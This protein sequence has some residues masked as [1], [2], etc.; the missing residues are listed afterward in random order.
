MW[1][2]YHR[3]RRPFNRKGEEGARGSEEP[4][5]RVSEQG[6]DVLVG[7]FGSGRDLANEHQLLPVKHLINDPVSADSQAVDIPGQRLHSFRSGLI[8]QCQ[9]ARYEMRSVNLGH[10]GELSFDPSACHLDRVRHLTGGP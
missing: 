6:L 8:R 9:Q 4:L 10:G 3:A 5:I 1:P 2:P 7:P